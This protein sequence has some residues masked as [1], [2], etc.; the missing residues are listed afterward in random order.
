M[1]TDPSAPQPAFRWPDGKRAALSLSF[2]DARLS[3]VDRALPIMD[4]HDV[5]GTFYVSLGRVEARMRE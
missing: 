1:P 5:K 3:Q 2:D 4:A